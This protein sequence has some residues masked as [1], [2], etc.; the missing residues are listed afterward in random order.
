MFSGRKM[1]QITYEDF[2]GLDLRVGK[3]V[4]AEP[5]PEARNP[6]Y[7]LRVDFGEEVGVL[8][9]SAQI[10]DLYSIGELVGKLVVGV[11]NLPK[12]QIGKIISECLVTG[13]DDDHGRV[14]LCVPER[15]VPIGTRL[16]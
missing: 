3:I 2:R 12:K 10:T 9:S 8:K 5:L 14:V 13:F 15:P 16:Y 11:A 6:S 7:V 1:K 4:S